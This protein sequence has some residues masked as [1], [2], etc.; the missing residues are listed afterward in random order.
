MAVVVTVAVSAIS[1]MVEMLPPKRRMMKSFS[2]TC[3]KIAIVQPR[4]AW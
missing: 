3:W 2:V 4:H 1:P